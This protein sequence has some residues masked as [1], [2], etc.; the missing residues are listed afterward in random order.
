MLA[1][2]KDQLHDDILHFGWL[3]Q[4]ARLKNP[5]STDAEWIKTVVDVVTSLHQDGIII[6]GRAHETD[7]TVLIDAWPERNHELR[8]RIESAINKANERDRDF[9]VWIQLVDHAV[10]EP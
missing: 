4:I 6:V 7:G 1:E 9:C 5:H 3:C 10:R 8:A 2:I